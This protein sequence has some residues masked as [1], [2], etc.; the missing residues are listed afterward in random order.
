[1]S[2][3]RKI[4][5]TL[6]L[7][8]L[9]ISTVFILLTHFTVKG[10]IEAGLEQ[11]RSQEI[12]LIN[13]RLT[14]Y[15][16]E[17]NNSWKNIEQIDLLQDITQDHPEL[18]VKDNREQVIYDKGSSP[19]KLVENLGIKRDITISNSKVGEFIYYDPEMANFTKIMIGIPISVI[20]I[21]LI[22]STILIIISLFI[23]YRLS[24]WLASP[25]QELLP[26]IKRLGKGEFGIRVPV[27]T[28][29]EYG[30]IAKAFNHMS[31][32]L[33]KA[34]IVRKNLTA[35]VAHELRTPLTIINGKL[36]YLQQQGQ[37]IRPE[38]LLPIQDELI[39]LNQIVEDLRVLSLAEAGKLKLN[40]TPTNMVDLSCRLISSL[41]PLA[42]EKNISMTLDVQTNETTV[43][44][45]ENRMKQVFLNLLT[46]AIRYTPNQGKIYIRLF[47][48]KN[49]LK[50]IVEDTGKG[51]EP[52]YLPYLFERFYRTDE[53]RTRYSGGTGLGLAIAKQYV[54][55]H[56]GK[57]EVK[58]K[59]NHGTSF[60]V[61]LPYH[62]EAN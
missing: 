29:D 11:T 17:N 13:K 51:I 7:T 4:F 44:V 19:L 5:Y 15:Y 2:F 14:T 49:A 27:N 30:K 26:F 24:K 43:F 10:T 54:V 45:D 50:I 42:E 20:I 61:Y 12:H 16:V 34:E 31:K 36:D 55:S 18:V 60:I 40:K 62:N 57:I 56:N 59:V 22:T 3:H 6:A 9:G 48:E 46:N 35:D 58:S 1:M 21:L 37:M 52:E 25:L 39:R 53:A 32:E 47:K 28:K 41:E 33:E 38:V 8:I 23:A